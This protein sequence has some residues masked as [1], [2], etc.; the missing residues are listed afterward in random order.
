MVIHQG[1]Y[2]SWSALHELNLRPVRM[3]PSTFTST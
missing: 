2:R 1:Q 3:L